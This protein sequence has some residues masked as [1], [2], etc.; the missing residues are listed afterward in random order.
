[1]LIIAVTTSV[2]L[3]TCFVR[4]PFISTEI[5][6]DQLS[7]VIIAYSDIF[8]LYYRMI[9]EAFTKMIKVQN[10]TSIIEALLNTPV[11]YRDYFMEYPPIPACLIYIATLL[12]STTYVLPVRAP[13]AVSVFFSLT[14]VAVSYVAVYL[15]MKRSLS[16]IIFILPL[17]SIVFI[18][19]ISSAPIAYFYTVAIVTASLLAVAQVQLIHI[20]EK[21]GV[22]R[23]VML[24]TVLSPSLLF[25][26]CIQL[27]CYNAYLHGARIKLPPI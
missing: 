22:N 3:I 5:N 2:L 6:I 18:V 17:L 25:F 15:A 9:T 11:P 27:R 4:T 24:Y 1:V 23:Y 14:L 21:I 13:I 19:L 26:C 12:S 8:A 16:R 10:A 7:S 20:A